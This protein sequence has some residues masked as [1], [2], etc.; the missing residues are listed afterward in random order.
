LEKIMATRIT[1]TLTD[2]Q[3]IALIK[4]AAAASMTAEN[5]LLLALDF[6]IIDADLLP[7]QG[8]DDLLRDIEENPPK[9]P[10]RAS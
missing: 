5:R 4:L 1:V 6:A 8:L 10:V 3:A 9:N 2:E 7:V